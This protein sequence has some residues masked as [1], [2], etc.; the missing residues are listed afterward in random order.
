MLERGAVR[1]SPRTAVTAAI[2]DITESMKERAGPLAFGVVANISEAGACIRTDG[3]FPVG[4]TV[5]VQLSFRGEP[6]P[7]PV[8]GCVVWC[9]DDDH[10]FRY[11][12]RW[13]RR[14]AG[15]LERLIRE[16]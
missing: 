3:R 1:I 8:E 6:Q 12:L 5:L 7:L 2:E 14:A 10:S 9:G 4:E 16:C 13:L 11:G 15:R